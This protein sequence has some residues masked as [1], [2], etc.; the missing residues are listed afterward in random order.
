MMRKLRKFLNLT[1]QERKVLFKAFRTLAVVQISLYM[2]PF[3]KVWDYYNRQLDAESEIQ[4]DRPCVD[5]VA[6]AVNRIA[7]VFPKTECL[8]RA[9]TVHKM[10]YD[11]GYHSK[12]KIGTRKDEQGVFIAHAWIERFDK[13]IIGDLDQLNKYATF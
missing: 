11:Y 10:L 8:P 5:E 1:P 12:L 4:Q 7:D 3:Q 9:L 13:V 6:L 2:L